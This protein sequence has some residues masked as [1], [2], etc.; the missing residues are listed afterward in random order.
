MPSRGFVGFMIMIVHA[1]PID[2]LW[3]AEDIDIL[4][5]FH[6]WEKIQE[7]RKAFANFWYYSDTPFNVVRLPYL[8]YMVNDIV[9]CGAG[10]I[11]PSYHDVQRHLLD[12]IAIDINFIIDE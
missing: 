8:E 6:F 12:E 2:C 3:S 7:A 1:S 11:A 5:F 10:F 9:V 4:S